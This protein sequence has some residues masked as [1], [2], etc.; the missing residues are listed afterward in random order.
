MGQ[1]LATLGDY[2]NY[3][4]VCEYIQS[5]PAG[6]ESYPQCAMRSDV[7]KLL[8]DKFPQLFDSA[9]MPKEIK[10]LQNP[11]ANFGRRTPEVL[12]NIFQLLLCDV[13]FGSEQAYLDWCYEFNFELYQSLLWKTAMT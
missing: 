9:Q 12:C 8:V 1:T 13:G 4:K 7:M 5:L 11:F 3:P 2:T 10:S 6:L